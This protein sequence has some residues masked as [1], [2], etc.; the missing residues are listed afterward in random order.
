MLRRTIRPDPP[1]GVRCPLGARRSSCLCILLALSSNRVYCTGIGRAQFLSLKEQ[2]P[3]GVKLQR[4]V[5][6]GIQRLKGVPNDLVT[7][8]KYRC[9][10]NQ[11]SCMARQ[12]LTQDREG[13]GSA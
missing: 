6:L 13:S 4:D 3:G 2:R 5:S 10:P 12:I 11:A 9:G 8:F 7:R 1:C